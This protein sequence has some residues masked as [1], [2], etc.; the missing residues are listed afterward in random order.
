MTS[1][2]FQST[3]A[4]CP[5]YDRKEILTQRTRLLSS[6]FTTGRRIFR[7][8]FSSGCFSWHNKTD[9]TT[10]SSQVIS[11]HPTVSFWCMPRLATVWGHRRQWLI[12]RWIVLSSMNHNPIKITLFRASYNQGRQLFLIGW[13]D[14]HYAFC[15]SYFWINIFSL[16]DQTLNPGLLISSLNFASKVPKWFSDFHGVLII[17]LGA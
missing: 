4:Q 10:W 11:F 2:A 15:G 12:S 16:P 6:R 8:F 14:S 13:G 7:N 3:I 9:S 1:I 5:F 17:E